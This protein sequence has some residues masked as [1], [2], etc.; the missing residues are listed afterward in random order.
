MDL[1]LQAYVA[2]SGEDKPG[3]LDLG[4]RTFAIRQIRLFLFAGHDS[5]SSTIC[6]AFHLLS[7]NP[8]T[9]NHIRSEHDRVLGS[10]AEKAATLLED[11]PKLLQ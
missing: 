8:A 7:L 11:Y 10:D 3:R 1:V 5:R 6:Y 9:L 2:Q 4:F